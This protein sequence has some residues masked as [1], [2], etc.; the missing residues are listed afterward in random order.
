MAY[1][2]TRE[3]YNKETLQGNSE[4]RGSVCNAR[5]TGRTAVERGDKISQDNTGTKEKK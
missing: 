5:K 1:L 3:V 2:T 4:E